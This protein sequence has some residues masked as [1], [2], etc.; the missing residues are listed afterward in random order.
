MQGGETM[1][2]QAHPLPW[3]MSIPLA[4][5]FAFLGYLVLHLVDF[6]NLHSKL[7]HERSKN[8]ELE[9]EIIKLKAT[10]GGNHE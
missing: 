4:V 10:Q 2:A 7:N 8:T 1:T 9:Q 3:I 5:L 6:E